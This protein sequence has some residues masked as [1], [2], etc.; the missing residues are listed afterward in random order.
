MSQGKDSLANTFIVATVLC[1]VCALVVS[2]SAVVLKP[3][4]KRNAQLDRMKNILAV[5][6]FDEEEIRET[7]VEELFKG[8]FEAT[9]I[10]LDT[11]E[12]ASEAC[13]AAMDSAGKVLGDIVAEYEQL[14]ASK[15]KKGEEWA[16]GD[17]NKIAICRKLDKKEDKCGIKYRE[18]FS[19]VFKK[20]SADGKVETYV[21]PVRGMGLWSMMQGYMAVKPDFQTV[22]GLTFYDQKET[23]G[24]GGEVMNPQWKKKWPGKQIYDGGDVCLR[25]IKGDQSSNPYGVDGLAGATITSN[26]VS[27]MTKYWL[28]PSGFEPYIQKQKSGSSSSAV[29]QTVTPVETPA[30]T[31]ALTP[32]ATTEEPV[33]EGS[34]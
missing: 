17:D 28:G 14:W 22:V 33:L 20:K 26:G 5:A 13:K 24:L 31:P 29:I 11:G 9:I 18:K 15:S 4:Q 19:H 1:L 30:V 27:N 3:M 16:K 25:V 6:G 21:F 8:R 10:D 32:A 34:H 2:A 7:G 12:E 23:P